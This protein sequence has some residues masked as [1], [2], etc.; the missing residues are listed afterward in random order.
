M[1]R[2][3]C[4]RWLSLKPVWTRIGGLVLPVLF[5]VPVL[6]LI[7]FAEA[8]KEVLEKLAGDAAWREHITA[9]LV[10]WSRSRIPLESC[11]ERFSL[12]YAA[13]C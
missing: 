4:I 5:A 3:A 12:V 6:A 13:L 11:N 10:A 7:G 2:S 9:N 1:P 8:G